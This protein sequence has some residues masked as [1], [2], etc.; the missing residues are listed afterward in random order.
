MM[1]PP[2]FQSMILEHLPVR[3]YFPD[4]QVK[5]IR[6]G[7]IGFVGQTQEDDFGFIYFKDEKGNALH[8]VPVVKN[9][10]VVDTSTPTGKLMA[11]MFYVESQFKSS[12]Q[13]AAARELVSEFRTRYQKASDDLLEECRVVEHDSAKA[14]RFQATARFWLTA[15]GVM[16]MHTLSMNSS[17]Y[18]EDLW[19]ELNQLCSENSKKFSPHYLV[20]FA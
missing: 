9:E 19:T 4:L 5:R 10:W 14:D 6:D 18:P 3:W 20:E 12:R 7:V 17:D 2:S 8:E 16:E 13:S 15:Y 11:F 1:M